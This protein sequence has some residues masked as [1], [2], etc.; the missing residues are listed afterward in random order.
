[1]STVLDRLA[2]A[3]M[4][5]PSAPDRLL[6]DAIVG[7]C[8]RIAPLWPLKNF[9]AVNPF[10]GFSTQ[11][12]AATCATLHRVARIDMLMPR[13]FFCE[14]IT[15]GEIEDCDMAAALAAVPNTWAAPATVEALHQAASRE[16]RTKAVHPAAVATIAEVLDSLASGDRLVSRTAFMTDEISKWCAAYFDE[17]QSV[18][19]L[20][21]RSLPPYAGW[22]AAMRHDL[23]PEAMGIRNFRTLVGAMPEDCIEAIAAVIDRIGVPARAV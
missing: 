19:R 16:I 5:K 7:A 20:P 10:L 2:E 3:E 9:V 6:A 1:M 8:H 15:R 23:N 14:A 12:F 18:W 17:G 22:R 11:S 21:G 4:S 13:R